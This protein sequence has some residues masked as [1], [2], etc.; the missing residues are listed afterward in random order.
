MTEVRNEAKIDVKAPRARKLLIL[1]TSTGGGHNAAARA[2]AEAARVQGLMAEVRDCMAPVG[3]GFSRQVSRVYV[4][5]VQRKPKMFGKVYRLGRSVSDWDKRRGMTSPVYL[6]NVGCSAALKRL[7][8]AEKPDAV[9]CTHLYAGQMMTHLKRHGGFTG[10][11]AFVMTDYTVVPFQ[12]EVRCDRLYLSRPGLESAYEGRTVEM[13]VFGIPVSP[14]CRVAREALMAEDV[15][16]G[17]GV[18]LLG[19]SM[20]AG[21]LPQ[22]VD[23]LLPLMTSGSTLQVVCGSN[24]TARNE[25]TA[26]YAGEGRVNVLGQVD[27]M[28]RRMAD[29]CVVVSKAGGLTSSEVAAIGRPFVIWKPIEGC[30]TENARYFT[31]QHM[32]L[33]AKTAEEL[34]AQVAHLLQD[35]A[36]RRNMV[37]HQRET[38]DGLAAQHIVEDLMKALEGA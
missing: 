37:R 18:L 11:T 10:L 13:R 22:A 17:S 36:A 29:A 12:E 7:L 20:G 2:V 24:E 38:V 28:P 21:D 19:G 14:A 5:M 25:L 23:A 31:S 8:D 30:E 9:V 33:W 4:S 16:E 32:A 6:F 26:R 1:T 27:D 15:P 34:H 3:E 35:E